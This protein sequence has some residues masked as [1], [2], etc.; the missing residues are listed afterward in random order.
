MRAAVVWV[1][2]ASS[3]DRWPV[4]DRVSALPMAE[5]R[6]AEVLVDRVHRHVQGRGGAKGPVV[7]V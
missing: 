5:R 2:V 7:D 4:I 1:D 6:R 3:R